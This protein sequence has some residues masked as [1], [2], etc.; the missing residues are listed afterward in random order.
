MNH[1]KLLRYSGRTLWV[2]L[3]A[4]IVISSVH[5]AVTDIARA[6]IFI[7]TTATTE[8]KPNV[9]FVLDDS[10]S[11]SWSFMPDNADDFL[12]NYGFPSSQCN[13]V[14]YNPALT[15]LPP[16]NADG[17]SYP[18]M[19]FTAA[20]YDG[21]NTAS[22]AFNTSTGKGTVNLSTSFV[23]DTF[24]PYS[25]NSTYS[26]YRLPYTAKAAFYYVY[27]GTQTTQKLKDYYNTNSVFYKECNSTIGSTTKVDGVHPVNSLFT[28]VAV[29]AT[30]GPG[31][32]DERVNF[33][34]W[35]SYY[36]TRMLM[37][38][39]ASGRA[40][41]TM[42]SHFRVG[43][44]SIDNNASPS[45]LNID[46]FTSTQK[47]NW[48][49]KLY[50]SVADN[51]TPLREALANTGSLYAGKI[52][53]LNGTTVTNPVQYSCQQN[54]VILSTD[55]FW[56]GTDSDVKKLD[57]STMDNQDGILPRPYS[58]GAAS[59]V[60]SVT[61]YSTTED[62]QTV[63]TGSVITK[64]WTKFTTT[65]GAACTTASGSTSQPSMTTSAYLNIRSKYK[66]ALALAKTD[67]SGKT[68]ACYSL[69][70]S[71][72]FCRGNKNGN[73]VQS[74]SS[75][76]DSNGK[77]WYL[78]SKVSGNTGCATSLTAF[79]SSYSSTN[80]VCPGAVSTG[81]NGFRVTTT[82]YS[83]TET[84]SGTTSTS[85]DRYIAL[86]TRTQVTTNGIPGAMGPLTP[87]TLSF[88]STSENVSYNTTAATSNLCGGQAVSCPNDNVTWTVGT[89]SPNN[90]CIL[91][92]SLPQAGTTDPTATETATAGTTS[93][94]TVIATNGP[95]AENT[96]V[97]GTS[98]GGT[99]NTLADV[100][101]HY[102]NT[103]LRTSALN[104]CDGVAPDGSSTDLCTPN[105]VP[106]NGLDTATWQHM[107]TFTL[108]L[109]ARGKMVFSPTY[110]SD[111]TGD[112]YDVLKGNIAGANN[113]SWQSSSGAACNWPTP[114]SD[115]IENIDDLW[116]AAVNGHGNYFSA[117]DPNTL[118]NALSSSLNVI[119]NTPQPGTA[120]AAATTN[121]KIT[122]ANNFQFSSYFKSVEWCGELIRQS[123]SLV[124]GT[125][126][127]FDPFTALSLLNNYKIT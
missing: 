102:Y 50:G 115:N 105:K 116:H 2:L 57:G 109:G 100:A 31:G 64:V 80:G 85:V 69:G 117:T 49:S 114:G 101:A 84:I 11:M 82:P 6:P 45:F 42:D 35:Y 70:N 92:S 16:M 110:L 66:G 27:S 15:Y 39:T 1:C 56:N 24:T 99:S 87:S 60:T 83:Q 26:N 90:E 34:N 68:G 91:T 38:K 5:A 43:Y 81:L 121:P 126:P 3:I 46:D 18:N 29:S 127:A 120:A 75:V 59:T 37:M 118:K 88:S 112:Y 106:P 28:L 119:I 10:G 14:Y 44:L 89:P 122:S 103:N 93:A 97:T 94:Y 8:V 54:Y 36:R 104:N 40:F 13:G 96:A 71:A 9:M 123:M 107:T 41:Q 86:Q 23:A 77:T 12:G 95:T 108:G 53:T 74:L 33:A 21:Y 72:W 22:S 111:T 61:T 47:S 67:P 51:G 124:D 4:V 98:Q 78:V 32:T 65:V 25:A 62:R 17:T 58:D 7:A 79:G 52:S 48:Y 55:G 30:S 125:V 73:P 113:C 19:S 63:T 76:T 20:Q